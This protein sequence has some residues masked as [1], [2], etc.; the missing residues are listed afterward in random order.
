MNLHADDRVQKI[1]K[2]ELKTP[3]NMGMFGGHKMYEVEFNGDDV[4]MDARDVNREY[5]KLNPHPITYPKLN[6]SPKG[7]LKKTK[8]NPISNHP[9]S[10]PNPITNLNDSRFDP[11]IDPRIYSGTPDFDKQR[12]HLNIKANDYK[13]ANLRPCKGGIESLVDG[14]PTR[15]RKSYGYRDTAHFHFDFIDPEFQNA[16]NSIEP[17]ERG[18]SSTRNL[19]KSRRD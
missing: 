16:N 7:I 12:S 5:N 18:G 2:K 9:I 1:D 4:F 19:N 8:H 6:R 14:M 15:T 13:M 17:W 3:P 11:R 10:N